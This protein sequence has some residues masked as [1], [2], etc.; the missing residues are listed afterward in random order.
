MGVPCA[1]MDR[2]GVLI[3]DVHLLVRPD[4]VRLAPGAASALAALRR[5]GFRV[6]V[7]T[8]QTV[9]AR[10]LAEEKDVDRV[11]AEIDR[12][13]AAAGPGRIDAYY[14][15]PHHPNA[16]RP[17]YRIDCDCRKPKPGLLLRA[18]AEHG[19]DLRASFMIGDRITDVIAGR[20][21]GCGTIMVE[22]GAHLEPP[23]ETGE[24][25]DPTVK[26]DRT[27]RDLAEAAAFI[28][29]LSRGVT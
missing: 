10:G 12:Q 15:C 8:N 18:A 7:V 26:P 16:T 4:Q 6:V 17:A 14:V 24:P 20:V 3:E 29:G 22:T 27:C 11:H 28:L 21:A 9:V 25:I 5:G 19:I 13:L 23:I 2:D 1:F